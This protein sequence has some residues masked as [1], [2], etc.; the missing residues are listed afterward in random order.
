[1]GP[2]DQLVAR[3][4]RLGGPWLPVLL[5]TAVGGAA[6]RVA[7]PY[8]LGRAI[9]APGTWRMCAA[10]VAGIVATEVAEVWASGAS[11]ARATARLRAGLIGHIL[12]VGPGLSRKHAA[13]DVVTRVCLNAEE[14]GRA[15]EAVVTAVSALVPTIGALVALALIDPW[16]AV[17]LAAGLLVTGVWVRGFLR[18]TTEIAS[19][20]QSTQGEIAARLLD[21]L[22][23]A[24]TIA[25]AGAAEDE[26]RRVLAP[27]PQ[28]RA[29][30]LR[31]WRLSATAGVRAGLMVPL[32]EVAVLG[33]GGL[34]IQAGALTVGGLYAAARY[35]V[36]A[37]G[38]G[39]ALGHVG[40][41]ARARAAAGRLSE[42]A[43]E[44][45]TTYGTRELPA[46]PGRLEFRGTPCGDL[47]IPGG[48]TVA[49]AGKSGS[50]K[51]LVAALA[52]RLTDPAHGEVLLDGTPLPQLSRATLRGAVGYAFERP[53]LFGPTL[54][55]AIAPVAG[56]EY[57]GSAARAA[58]AD[59]FIRRLPLG[60]DT[61][62]RDAPMSGG[63]RQRIGLARCFATAQAKGSR[64][65]ILD[66]ATSSLD[67]VTE[68][69][70]N[71][72]IAGELHGRTRLVVARRAA[73]AARA[74]LV[75]WLD[76]GRVRAV[77]SHRT[78][79]P[80][81]DYRDVFEAG[82]AEAEGAR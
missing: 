13:G 4:V 16:L 54:G 39:S 23:G 77:A 37:A 31:L 82:A 56:R 48:A 20:Y 44:P 66:D 25:A 18:D 49:L 5:F 81:P 41:L 45:R 67:T 28:L 10:V 19:G 55:A 64:L 62:P 58:R 6:L 72:A 47:V 7:L 22:T 42:L 12:G 40:R 69:Q 59:G 50:G 17:V 78:L 74:D 43:D 36:L 52:G 57:A 21:A 15:P 8:T 35:A 76:E 61:P 68:R 80:D 14:T 79:W 65:L 51:S 34:R 75:V 60:F 27:L 33:V 1:M 70:V 2:A 71:D 38:I 53:I 3:T 11:G 9:D 63:E 73:T 30:G 32:V 29:Y 24:R 26:T 46:G